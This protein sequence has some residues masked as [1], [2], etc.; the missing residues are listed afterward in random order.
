MSGVT[1]SHSESDVGPECTVVFGAGRLGADGRT[2][3]RRVEIAFQLCYYARVGPHEDSEGVE[4]LGYVVE[5]PIPCAAAEF[6]EWRARRWRETGNCPDPGFYVAKQSVWLDSLPAFFRRNS[7]HYVVDGRDGYVEV[8]ARQ[9]R[10]RE[11]LWAEGLRE[12][13]PARGSA[14]AEG[15]GVA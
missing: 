1:L 9:F 10:W 12:S 7:R 3:S 13:A 11:W 14:V 4:M 8:I 2:D 6:L 5:P 15:E